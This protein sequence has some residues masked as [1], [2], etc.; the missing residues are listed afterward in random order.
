LPVVIGGRLGHPSYGIDE[1]DAARR[2][3]KLLGTAI[4]LPTAIGAFLD[5]AS[6]AGLTERGSSR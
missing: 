1:T 6:L 2:L 4:F 5:F 3:A